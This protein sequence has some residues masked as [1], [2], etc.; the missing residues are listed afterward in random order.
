[1]HTNRPK[2]SY[3]AEVIGARSE[4]LIKNKYGKMNT[5]KRIGKL[6]DRLG[7]TKKMKRLQKKLK[8][9]LSNNT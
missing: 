7:E 4:R 2:E 1:M 5:E 9:Q 3:Q 6:K 8:M